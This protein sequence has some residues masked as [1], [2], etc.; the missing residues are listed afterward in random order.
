MKTSN[1]ISQ[2]I[3][4]RQ[5]LEAST[6]LLTSHINPDGD[7]I[8][9]ELAL[10]YHL[11]EMGKDCRIINTS[12]TPEVYSFLNENKVIETY[13]VDHDEW[14]KK[15]ALVIIL[16][17]GD[18]SRI[19]EM[20]NLF[21]NKSIS[22][23]IDHHPARDEKVYTYTMINTEEPSTGS[24]VYKY[25]IHARNNK[26]LPLNIAVPLY[27]ALI[28]DTG[29][30]RYSNTN[31]EAHHMAAHL[32]ESGVKPNEIQNYVYESRPMVQ[33][34][35]LGKIID[36]LQFQFEK[37]FVWFIV[38]SKMMSECGASHKDIDGFTD[39]ARTIQGV[40]ISCMILELPDNNIRLNFRSK[41]KYSVNDIA[42][43]FKGGGHP[44]AAGAVIENCDV[45][46][47]ENLVLEEM[48]SKFCG[49]S[50]VN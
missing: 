16:D 20:R 39:F 24:I 34:K 7:G 33:V 6:I 28:T 44:F 1:N 21:S 5:I 12:K 42:G 32:I 19:G 45:T 26:K 14:I 40:E 36:G 4:D 35:L 13:S 10:Y 8:G 37:Q 29:S 41:G 9:S 15:A 2:A 18:I 17:I 47:A 25:L 11:S 46:D 27:V 49:S 48:K 23:C 43:K 22:I 3:L 30:F 31:S 50:D 38:N